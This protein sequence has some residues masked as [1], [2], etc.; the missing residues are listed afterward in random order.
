MKIT[1]AETIQ[2]SEKELIDFINAELDW[3]AIEEMILEKHKLQLQDEVV[4]K[5]GDIIVQDN[6]IAYQLDFDIKVSLSLIFNRQG[7]CIDIKTPDGRDLAEH[8]LSEELEEDKDADY[9]NKKYP[10]ESKNN[11]ELQNN[12]SKMAS[13]I[14]EM[15]HE[16][17]QDT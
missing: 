6:Q 4:Y 16:I 11:S 17:N 1:S 3:G 14:A 10:E 13:N 15:I 8:N 7:D 9:K 5:H 2:S 12:W